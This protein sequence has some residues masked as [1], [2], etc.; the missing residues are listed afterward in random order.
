MGWPLNVPSGTLSQYK[1]RL[2]KYGSHIKDKTVAK[3]TYLYNGDPYT[4]KTASLY[5]DG[6]LACTW[7]CHQLETFSALLALSAGNSPVTGGFPSQRPVTRSLDVFFYLRLSKRL[8]KQSRRW[9]FE[10][11]SWSLWR[12]CN[13]KK[14]EQIQV[15]DWL[16]W[17]LYSISVL[18]GC[19]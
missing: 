9:W 11:P 18:H 1:D 10:K 16:C 3:P 12:H 13:V 4:G 8:S 6:P 15:F 14:S 17:E 7:L 19:N 2:Y 5:W